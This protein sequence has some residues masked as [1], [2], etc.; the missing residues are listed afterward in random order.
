MFPR[1]TITFQNCR[2]CATQTCLLF[3]YLHCNLVLHF[4]LDEKIQNFF[5]LNTYANNTIL[6]ANIKT[7]SLKILISEVNVVE[8]HQGFKITSTYMICQLHDYKIS[9]LSVL[10]LLEIVKYL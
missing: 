5:Q 2:L 10:R 6:E 7:F 9:V 8:G 3:T 4:K 1:A